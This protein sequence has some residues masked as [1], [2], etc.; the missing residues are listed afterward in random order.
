M[1]GD[2]RISR[3]EFAKL[4]KAFFQ[5]N[6]GMVRGAVKV[7]EQGMLESFDDEAEKPVSAAFGAPFEASTERDNSR[8]Y[9]KFNESDD[10]VSPIR[11]N[12]KTRFDLSPTR[13]IDNEFIDLEDPIINNVAQNATEEMISRIF[14]SVDQTESL[15]FQEF[16]KAAGID[17]NIL[18]WFES[19]GSVF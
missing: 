2:G 3:L 18:A 6:M 13:A 1:N 10:E 7:L 14:E 17:V 5:L 12:S 19:L 4:F 8:L 11:D 15:S 9:T 16:R